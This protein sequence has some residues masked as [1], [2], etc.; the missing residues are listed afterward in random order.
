MPGE[1]KQPVL[2]NC[3]SDIFPSD[4]ELEAANG[5]GRI[6]FGFAGFSI[7]RS[8]LKTNLCG[9]GRTGLFSLINLELTRLIGDSFFYRGNWSAIVSFEVV[10][11]KRGTIM[12]RYRK[13]KSKRQLCKMQI[14]LMLF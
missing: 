4:H 2:R 7:T 6:G 5:S 14:N 13:N 3:R 1:V 9:F 10:W 8:I 12:K 11:K